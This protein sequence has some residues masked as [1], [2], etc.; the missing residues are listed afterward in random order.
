MTLVF[1]IFISLPNIHCWICV[2]QTGMCCISSSLC[3]SACSS[4]RAHSTCHVH[5]VLLSLQTALVGQAR[6]TEKKA[7]LVP[8]PEFQPP[9]EEMIGQAWVRCPRVHPAVALVPFM[10]QSHLAQAWILGPT[11]VGRRQFLEKGVTPGWEDIPKSFNCGS[12]KEQSWECI[13]K[14]VLD[15]LAVCQAVLQ[16][17]NW[18]F[19]L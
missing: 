14:I 11:S 8:Q 10:A 19:L 13:S 16:V 9:R 18:Q 1:L 12:K 2:S 17:R 15:H 3:M 6:P 7:A 5:F 4:L